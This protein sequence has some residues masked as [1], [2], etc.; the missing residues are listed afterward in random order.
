MPPYAKKTDQ[1]DHPTFLKF[2]LR[3]SH[4]EEIPRK[5]SK[6]QDC[7]WLTTYPQHPSHLESTQFIFAHPNLTL[8]CADVGP[9]FPPL[10]HGG[11]DS[12][13]IPVTDFSTYSHQDT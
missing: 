3:H 4:P 13:L 6:A 11:K 7:L 10:H 8:L 5:K 1:S 9:E 2:L 12:T